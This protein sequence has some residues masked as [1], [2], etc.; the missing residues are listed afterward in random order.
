M[1]RFSYFLSAK[2]S[3]PIVLGFLGEQK[4]FLRKRSDMTQI[5][6]EP[7]FYVYIKTFLSIN[8]IHF[9]TNKL[10]NLRGVVYESN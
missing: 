5:F 7:N 6:I 10:I 8:Q 9:L 4:Q 2:K 3:T 1:D